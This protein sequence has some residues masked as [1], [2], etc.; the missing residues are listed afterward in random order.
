MNINIVREDGEK[1][2]YCNAITVFK[3]HFGGEVIIHDMNGKGKDSSFMCPHFLTHELLQHGNN[4]EY[5]Y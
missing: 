4:I 2:C 3:P 1:G 5:Y